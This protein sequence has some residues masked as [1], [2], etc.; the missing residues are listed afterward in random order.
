VSPSRLRFCRTCAGPV[1]A[2]LNQAC[3]G[4]DA[5]RQEVESLLAEE[6]GAQGFLEV[7][8]IEIPS[9]MFDQDPSQSLCGQQLGPYKVLSLLG[10]GSMR[11][12]WHFIQGMK[13][14]GPESS[15]DWPPIER[16]VQTL[17]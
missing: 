15:R 5:L 13:M 14:R 12:I 1:A 7:P 8:A 6:K 11:K 9:S 4:D 3:A 17:I 2:Y 10:V 16:T